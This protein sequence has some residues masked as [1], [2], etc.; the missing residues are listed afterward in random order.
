MW[1]PESAEPIEPLI[2]ILQ[3]RAINRIQ[4]PLTVG[5]YRSETI[6]PQDFQMLRN[7]RLADRELILDGRGDVARRHLTIGEELQNAA[8]YWLPQ[9]V[10][11]VHT[12]KLKYRLI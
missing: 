11:R 3:R 6:V 7:R 10:E 12:I 8:P 1:C 4:P 2:D 5:A 9:D